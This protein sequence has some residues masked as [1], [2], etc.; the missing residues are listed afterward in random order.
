MANNIAFQAMGK[1]VKLTANSATPNNA[2]VLAD[3]PCQQYRI[4]NHSAQPIYVWISPG[5]NPVNVAAPTGSGNNAT[6]AYCIPNGT[7]AIVTGPQC[8]NTS[9]VQISVISETN[10][11]ECYI[12]PGEG[13]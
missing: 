12:T 4:A 6:Y 1:T 2:P 3:S 8:T 5:T 7:V 13:L 10:G 9:N 11:P